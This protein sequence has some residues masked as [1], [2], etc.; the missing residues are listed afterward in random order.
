MLGVYFGYLLLWSG[1]IWVP[2]TAH[3]INNGMAVLY[4]HY[5]GDLTGETMLDTVGTTE[6]G[7]YLLYLSVFVT[8]LV[9]GMIYLHE[10]GNKQSGN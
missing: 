2:V 10:K 1:S 6:N 4:Y 7:H 3:L 9:I 8:S 5:A